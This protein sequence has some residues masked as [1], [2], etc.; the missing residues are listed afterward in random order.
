MS[1]SP[2]GWWLKNTEVIHF[3][4]T[5]QKNELRLFLDRNDTSSIEAGKQAQISVSSE[6]LSS[7]VVWAL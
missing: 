1:S 5:V 6:V 3:T 2:A 4:V 7:D